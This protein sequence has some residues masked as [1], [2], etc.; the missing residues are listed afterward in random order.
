MADINRSAKRRAEEAK[1]DEKSKA[2]NTRPKARTDSMKA[3]RPRERPVDV[4]P[5]AEAKDQEHIRKFRDG[6]SVRGCSD[7][8]MTGK[9]FSGTY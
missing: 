9:K 4:S 8:Q 3:V 7:G 2:K 5:D 1:M 6:G